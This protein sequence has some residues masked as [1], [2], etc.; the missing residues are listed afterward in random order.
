MTS[1]FGNV[2]T[3]IP[4]YGNEPSGSA[5][6]SK[7][8]IHLKGCVLDADH[9]GPCDVYRKPVPEATYRDYVTASIFAPPIPAGAPTTPAPDPEGI[10]V[11]DFSAVKM[12]QSQLDVAKLLE[13]RYRALVREILSLVPNTAHRE[14][15]LGDLLASKMMLMLA[16]SR[17]PEASL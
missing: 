1:K 8:Y 10:Q 16:I 7:G 17:S 12:N 9:V 15:A 4:L 3:P 11:S 6:D 13:I 14:H 2:G 5:L